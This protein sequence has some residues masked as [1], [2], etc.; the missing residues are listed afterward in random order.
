ME[1]H[2]LE[3]SGTKLSSAYER[4]IHDAITGDSTLF[5][6]TEEVLE[7]WKSL[8]PVINSWA[9]NTAIPLY[10]YP[11]GTW[12]PEK[13]EKLIECVNHTWR[14]PCKS[15]TDDCSYCEL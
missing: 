14:Y 7:A 11:A 15:L 8:M 4:L 3:L 10:G 13:A 2:Y 1:F 5:T 12:G 9:D 6:Q